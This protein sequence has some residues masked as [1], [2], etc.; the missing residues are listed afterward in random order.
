MLNHDLYKA[1]RL[2]DILEKVQKQQR[3]ELEDALRLWS[4]E[5]PLLLA[6]LAHFKR[7]SLHGRQTTYVLNQQINYTNICVNRCT[8]CSYRRHRGQSE[9]FELGL[10]EIRDKLKSCLDQPITEIHVV[11]GC[12]PDLSLDYYLQ[13][14]ALAKE[15]RPGAV[16]KCFTAVE[17]DH[18]A[19]QEGL[20]PEEVLRRLKQAGLEMLPGGGAEIFAPRVRSRI[21]PTKIS[22]QKWLQICAA[23]HRLGIQ[24]N[25]TMLFGHLETVQDRLEHLLQLRRQQDKTHGF[26]CFIPLPFQTENNRLQGIRKITGLEELKTIAIS[27]LLLD[28]I[29]HIKSYWVMLGLKQAQV[30][31]HWG[32][33]DLDGTVV[34]EKIGHMAGADSPQILS[35]S[36]LEEMI[37]DCDLLPVQ[38]NARFKKVA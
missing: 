25:C 19:R 22:G 32:A 2:E 11:G 4:C 16:L 33:D 12:H 38:R 35:R 36:E 24:T 1:Y 28:N 20:P 21:C 15:L 5:N 29:P 14:L 9:A 27:R 7:N 23:A 31:L 13:L 30:A 8:F 18:F 37:K 6:Q 34:E 3:L 10:E 17:I 26:L